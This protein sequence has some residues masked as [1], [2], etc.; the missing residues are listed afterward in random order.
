MNERQ[1]GARSE[2]SWHAV[3]SAA[4]ANPAENYER[5]FVPA[6]GAPC[7]ADLVET[8]A[9]RPG[10]RVLDVA[11]GT[12]VVARLAAARVGPGG[13]VAGLDINPAMLAVAGAAKQVPVDMEWHQASIESMPLEDGT[14]DVVLCQ[15]GIQFVEDIPAALGEIRRVLA[16]GGR[17]VVNLP[18]PTPPPFAAADDAFGRHIGEGAAGFLRAVFSL[19]DSKQ[20]DSLLA[21]AGFRNIVI[22]RVVKVLQL[23]APA[24][25]LWQ[26]VLSTPLAPVVSQAS[27][28]SR[29]ALEREVVEA[30]QPYTKGG[31]IELELGITTAVAYK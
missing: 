12:G 23:P 6:I 15:F 25:F 21:D 13:M 7:A 3:V 16:P 4:S 24:E 30:W 17:F 5:Y 11:C 2:T 14:F 1:H 31:G 9:P 29:D 19:H 18:G 28:E 27:D 20:V 22:D 8:A 26:Y 10:E